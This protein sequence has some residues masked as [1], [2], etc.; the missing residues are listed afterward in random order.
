MHGD[1]GDMKH[2]NEE[3]E[4]HSQHGCRRSRQSSV[5][6]TGSSRKERHA[7]KVRP[8]WP[9]RH[10]RGHQSRYETAVQEML[11]P[12]NCKGNGNEYSPERLAF[13]HEREARRR[14]YI[15]STTFT[16]LQE[17]N[18]SATAIV[19]GTIYRARSSLL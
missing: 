16:S 17:L 15:V 14:F 13:V 5:E 9:S 1:P 2:R 10:P 18:R 11:N 8:K 4:H 12:E 3:K 7:H 6:D 19:L